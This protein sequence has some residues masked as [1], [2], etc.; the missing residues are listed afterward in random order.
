MLGFDLPTGVT[1]KV[2]TTRTGVMAA[3]VVLRRLALF[4]SNAYRP[5]AQTAQSGV[6]DRRYS[7]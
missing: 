6:W 2:T 7:C 3:V 5:F 4:A 1:D